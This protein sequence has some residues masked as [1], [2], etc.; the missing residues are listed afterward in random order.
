MGPFVSSAHP[1]IKAGAITQT[2][3][4]I[5]RSRITGPLLSVLESNPAC[6]IILVPS[7]RDLVGSS[8]CFPQGM[9]DK[10][11]V[12]TASAKV[13]LPADTPPPPAIDADLGRTPIIFSSASACCPI[14]VYS[15]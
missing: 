5:F 6:N 4:E 12:G 1:L 8:V 11:D 3:A 15:T 7:V 13:R 2:P 10:A 14:L 9:F